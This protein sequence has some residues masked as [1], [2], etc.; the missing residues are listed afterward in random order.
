MLDRRRSI[1]LVAALVLAV[2]AAGC[3][4]LKPA[5][6]KLEV[7][8][9]GSI[10]AEWT[11]DEPR[12]NE[13]RVSGYVVNTSYYFATRVRVLVEALDRQGNVTAQRV[14][15]VLGG[16]TAGNRT[17]FEVRQLPPADRYR[18]SVPDYAWREKPDAL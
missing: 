8:E 18:V 4:S 11:V 13:P 7:G 1:G 14:A 12:F 3:G 16:V 2:G 17:Y 6:D 15:W 10:H 5:P 9:G